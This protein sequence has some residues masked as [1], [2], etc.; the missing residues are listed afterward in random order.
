MPRRPSLPLL[1]PDLVDGLQD[2]LDG[3]EAVTDL[4][5][6]VGTVV[7]PGLLRVRTVATAASLIDGQAACIRQLLDL[8]SEP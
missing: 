1:P 6:L 5:A 8:R 3:I 4:L 2:A 7:D